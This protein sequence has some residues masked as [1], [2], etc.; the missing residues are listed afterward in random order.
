MNKKYIFDLSKNNTPK[1]KV[2]T[3]DNWLRHDIVN[4]LSAENNIGL[5]LG[6]ACG[7]YS[8][9]MIESGKFKKFYGVDIYGDIHDTKEYVNTLKYLGVTN[10]T[11]SLLRMDF[12]SALDLF[13]D[14]YFDFIYID[15][16]A[17]TGEEGGKTIIDWSK[18]LK[19]GGILAGDDYHEDW[20]LVIW[21]VNDFAKQLGLEINLTDGKE[22]SDYCKY[23]TWYIKKE[24]W[25]EELV[26]NSSLYKVAMKE[27]SRINRKRKLRMLE[28][29]IVNYVRSINLFGNS[30]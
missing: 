19:V 7:I 6:V 27:K 8:K 18:K 24:K 26:V 11:Y 17:H 14:E 23:P 9:R 2:N 10:S 12:D 28:K 15:G 13:E 30:S 21:A 20:P 5:E 25:S 3:K 4:E 1:V 29:R 22:S 16:F